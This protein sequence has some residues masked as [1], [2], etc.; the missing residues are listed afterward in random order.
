MNPAAQVWIAALRDSHERLRKVVEPLT[1][2]QLTERAYPS[3]WSI[4][5]VL[6]HLG[7]GAEIFGHIV[8]S[9]STGQ[10]VPGREVMAPIWDTWNA[11]DPAEQAADALVADRRLVERLEELVGGPSADLRMDVFGRELDLAGLVGMRLSEHALHSWD[12]AVALEP[13]LPVASQ[14]ADLLIDNISWSA[15]RV[16]KPV[17]A[18]RTVRISTTDPARDFLLTVGDSVTLEQ[19]PSGDADA[20]LRLPAESLLRLVAGRL[21]PAHTPDS[22]STTGVELDDLRAVFPGY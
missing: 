2:A 19:S 5:Q 6:S 16:G 17:G 15:S 20:T 10:A 9:G 1:P 3:E 18:H 14:S 12:V 4:A 21:D 8:A 7:S 22:V 13:T 11:K